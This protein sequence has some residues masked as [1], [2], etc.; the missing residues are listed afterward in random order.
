MHQT[1]PTWPQTGHGLLANCRCANAAARICTPI[2]TGERNQTLPHECTGR[3]AS[4]APRPL[5]A[6]GQSGLE[7][8]CS[9]GGACPLATRRANPVGHNETWPVAARPSAVVA[10]HREQLC[11][12]CNAFALAQLNHRATYLTQCGDICQ[13][14]RRLLEADKRCPQINRLFLACQLPE[15]TG[16]VEPA[17]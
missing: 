7:P 9:R 6:T 5:A 1:L 15:G 4:N 16:E 14:G 3:N 12:T 11:A 8:P 2:P 10:L 13:G 17:C